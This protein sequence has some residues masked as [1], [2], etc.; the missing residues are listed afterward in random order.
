MLLLI[1]T[2]NRGLSSA[3]NLQAPLQL[4]SLYIQELIIIKY[5]K[6]KTSTSPSTLISL[7]THSPS[8]TGPSITRNAIRN[9]LVARKLVDSALLQDSQLPHSYMLAP[10]RLASSS[11]HFK[12]AKQLIIHGFQELA[13]LPSTSV[14]PSV[15]V[16]LE[17]GATNRISLRTRERSSTVLLTSESE[18]SLRPETLTLCGGLAYLN[19]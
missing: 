15:E 16:S 14:L 1:M 8:Q 2:V 4:R 17:I 13:S 6:C 11:S 18:K 10:N 19:N 3:Q 7:S 9:H 5:K 12:K